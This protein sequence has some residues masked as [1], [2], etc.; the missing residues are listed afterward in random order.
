MHRILIVG[1]AA[2]LFAT[3]GA[4][5]AATLKFKAH[6]TGASEV[7][8]NKTAGSGDLTASLDT[9]A[10]S[11]SYNV[12]YAGLTGPATMAHFHGPAR[13]GK[14]APPVVV[15]ANPASPISGTAPLTDTQ[16]AQLKAGDWYFNVHTA[17]NPGGEIRGQVKSAK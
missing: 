1:A 13:P 7:P 14:N 4:A 12:T 10:K 3:A 5:S 6:L 11:L 15:V 8:A 17:A 9:T 2:L 16:I